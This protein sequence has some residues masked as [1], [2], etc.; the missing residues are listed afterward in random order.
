MR[1]SFGAAYFL[2]E[3]EMRSIVAF[4]RET[5]NSKA[6]SRSKNEIE[7]TKPAETSYLGTTLLMEPSQS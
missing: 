3:I 6:V 4:E 7:A 2:D 5:K 1:M